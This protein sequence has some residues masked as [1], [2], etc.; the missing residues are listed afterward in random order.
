MSA[1]LLLHPNTKLAV[2]RYLDKGSHALLITGDAGAGKLTIARHIASR[3]LDTSIDKLENHPYVLQIGSNDEGVTIDQIRKLQQFVS[4]KTIGNSKIRRVIIV[5]SAEQMTTQAQN[6]LLK[7]L[8]EPPEDT[9]IL[10]TSSFPEELLDTIRS[11][12]SD[13]HVAPIGS[14]DAQNYF[15]GLGFSESKITSAHMLCAGGVGLM[16]AVL[17]GDAEHPLYADITLA[18]KLLSASKYER[19]L[20]VDSLCK[21][22]VEIQRLLLALKRISRAA[23]HASINK[24]DVK[25]SL[26]WKNRLHMI[27]VSEAISRT[28]ASGKLL[29]DNLFLAL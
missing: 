29:L 11:R 18:K 2:D 5:D 25:A 15:L 14:S 9:K 13:L 17:Q 27:S 7:T 12:V 6:A 28:N 10:L 24:G 22:R 20:E 26:Q 19:L 4:L 23:L 8:E 16:Q 21:S 3:T 1:D